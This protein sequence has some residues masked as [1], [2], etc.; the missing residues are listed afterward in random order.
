MKLSNRWFEGDGSAWQFHIEDKNIWRRLI[1]MA[2]PDISTLIDLKIKPE[3]MQ[4]DGEG[5]PPNYDYLVELKDEYFQ[6]I[7]TDNIKVPA[8]EDKV[9]AKV[10]NFILTLYRQDSAYFERIGGIVT[11]LI[12]SRDKWIGKSRIE[13]AQTLES[14]RKWFKENDHRKRTINWMLWF[15]DYFIKKYKTDEFY[16]KSINMLIDYVVENHEQ[17]KIVDVYNPA[18]WYPRGR[19]QINAQIFGEDFA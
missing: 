18:R 11:V 2:K 6:W 5:N 9:L 3:W 12:T 16:E 14:L 13:R 10:A 4:N 7:E 15:F 8:A 19:G 1:D 17:W